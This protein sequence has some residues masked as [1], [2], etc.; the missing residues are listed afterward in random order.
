M[1]TFGM[2][3]MLV[4]LVNKMPMFQELCCSHPQGTGAA[5]EVSF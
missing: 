5:V 4:E 1:V 2:S 3:A